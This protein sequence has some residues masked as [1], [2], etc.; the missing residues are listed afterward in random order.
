MLKSG[1]KIEAMAIY[2]SL[3]THQA[4]HIGLAARRG[5]LAA[6]QK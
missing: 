6:A 3:M 2:K 5:L 1:K 4:K